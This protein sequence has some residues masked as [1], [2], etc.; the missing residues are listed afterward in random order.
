MKGLKSTY[1]AETHNEKFP[2]LT[3]ERTGDSTDTAKELTTGKKHVSY[4]QTD[5]M[6][7]PEGGQKQRKVPPSE[8]KG[9]KEK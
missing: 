8:M 6:S 5:V 2:S 1:W 9:T 3:K 7:V 4:Y